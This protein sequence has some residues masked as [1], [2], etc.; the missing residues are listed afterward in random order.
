MHFVFRLVVAADKPGVY[1]GLQETQA[2]AVLVVR[3]TAE[4]NPVIDRLA[5]GLVRVVSTETIDI[6]GGKLIV[7]L[8]GEG[9]ELTAMNGSELRVKGRITK[10]ELVR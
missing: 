5:G 9:L 7:R 6:N 3:N 1:L 4:R 10:V 8:A 2:L